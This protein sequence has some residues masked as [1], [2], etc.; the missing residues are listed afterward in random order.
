VI[1][2]TDEVSGSQTKVTWANA[3]ELKY[4][5]NIMRSMIEKMLGKDMDT[6]LANLKN[7]LEK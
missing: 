7:I 5:L 4:P 2:T 6:S 3:S 1:L